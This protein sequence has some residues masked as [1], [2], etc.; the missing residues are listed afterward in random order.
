M[1]GEIYRYCNITIRDVK[2]KSMTVKTIDLN[3]VS[4]DKSNDLKKKF[5]IICNKNS[6][7]INYYQLIKKNENKMTRYEYMIIRVFLYFPFRFVCE[8]RCFIGNLSF[9]NLSRRFSMHA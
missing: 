2:S 8:C 4:V 1:K 7:H 3:D 9:L 5:F 6:I